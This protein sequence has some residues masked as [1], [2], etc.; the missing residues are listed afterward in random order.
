M[1]LFTIGLCFVAIGFVILWLVSLLVV[2]LTCYTA[3]YDERESSTVIVFGALFMML[4][5]GGLCVLS[6]VI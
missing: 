3:L 4:L 1:D 2:S 6:L 5:G